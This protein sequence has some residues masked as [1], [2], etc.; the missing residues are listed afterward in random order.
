MNN[1]NAFFLLFLVVFGC[2]SKN[3]DSDLDRISVDLTEEKT[4]VHF[5]QLIKPDVSI[6]PFDNF[7]GS[8]T[9]IFF[10]NIHKFRYY[11]DEFYVLDFIYGRRVFVFDKNGKFLRFIGH[12]GE[13]PGVLIQAMDFDILNDQVKVLDYGRFLNFDING[14]YQSMD[15]ID[16]FVGEKF[17]KYNEG[18]AFLGAGRDADNLVLATNE[19][20]KVSS[21][22]PYHTRALNVLLVNP[23]YYSPGGDAIYRRQLNDTLF[24]INDFQRPVPYLYIDF[25]QKKSNINELLSSSEPEQAI[26]NARSQYCNIFDFYETKDYKYLAFFVE[27]EAWAYFYSTKSCKSIV[28]KRSNLTDEITFDPKAVPVAVIGDKF[29]FKANPHNVLAG[30]ESY[31]S[32]SPHFSKLKSLSG[33]LDKEGNPILFLVEFDF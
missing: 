17:I 22:F 10:S 27:G 28:Y 8:E 26:S 1:K 9:P 12:V 3:Q 25:Q 30:I 7:D 6:I 2:G 13:G 23:M 11:K 21:F 15:K 19:F 4:D 32:T 24:K 16:G 18:Y 5:S 29:V 20:Q 31:Q 33:D 14:D